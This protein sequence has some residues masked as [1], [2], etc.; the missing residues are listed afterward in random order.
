MQFRSLFL[1]AATAVV[2]SS[3][4]AGSAGAVVITSGAFSVGIGAGGELYDGDANVGFRRNSDDFDALAASGRPDAWSANEAFAASNQD[5]GG[6]STVFGP[7]TASTAVTTTTT[8]DGLTILQS[9]SF[10]GDNILAIDTTITNST[11]DSL[12]VLFGRNVDFNLA[13]DQD[14]FFVENVFGPAAFGAI[15]ETSYLGGEQ[16]TGPFYGF[17]SC[18][19]GCNETGDLGAG[20]R[21]DLGSLAGGQSTHFTFYYGLNQAGQSAAQLVDQTQAAGAQYVIAGRGLDD[22]NAFTFGVG[23]LS[24]AVPEPATWAMMLLGFF[25]LGAALRSRRA[26]GAFAA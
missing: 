11:L 2:A 10:V 17:W 25:G 26:A 1:G 6:I 15:A 19:S 4:L 20:L 5:D 24:T 18:S 12:S 9:Y 8:D 21:L 14:D 23:G 22:A 3:L 16:T 7:A 13:T